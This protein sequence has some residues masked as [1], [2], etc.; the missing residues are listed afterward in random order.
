MKAICSHLSGNM[1]SGF[2]QY[3]FIFR[4]PLLASKNRMAKLDGPMTYGYGIDAHDAK[5]NKSPKDTML[6]PHAKERCNQQ[7]QPG[8]HKIYRRSHARSRR[9]AGQCH[10]FRESAESFKL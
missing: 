9:D 4:P 2:S 5:P 3:F 1:A 10:P 6:L 7:M 8:S